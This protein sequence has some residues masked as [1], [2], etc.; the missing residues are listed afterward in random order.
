MKNSKNYVVCIGPVCWDEY[1]T[2]ASWPREGDK[3]IVDYT[4][5]LAGGMIPNAACVFAG[6][7]VPTYLLDML[8][9][10]ASSLELVGDLNRYG[11][12]TSLI[13]YDESLP[14]AKCI[15]V[16]TPG[17]RTILVVDSH[18]PTVHPDAAQL[19]VLRG[20]AYVYTTVS[21]LQKFAHPLEL[22]RD[23]KA[24][25]AQIVFDVESATFSGRALELFGMADVL[26]FNE[27]G[28]AQFRGEKSED[29]YFRELFARGARVV[30]VTLGKKGSWT[31]T[32]TEEDRTGVIDF[33]VVDATGAG[34]TF[35]S[36]FVRCLMCGYDIHYAARFAN[37]AASL[38]VTRLGARG[39]VAS[40][41]SIEDA[42]KKYYR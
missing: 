15:I 40:A 41:E 38:A 21:E 25:G 12:D 19:E 4:G 27:Y 7:G 14:D 8:N 17:D 33:P 3:G 23:L 9:K 11:L 26:F 34:D 35:N 2:A 28:F 1:Y 5:R 39:G 10:S 31:R 16:R 18:K 22:V 29:D 32:P 30:T 20:A 37:A 6:Y 36:S 42:M 13:R 24:H